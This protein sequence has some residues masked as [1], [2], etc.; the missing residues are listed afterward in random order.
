MKKNLFQTADQVA[1]RLRAELTPLPEEFDPC[2]SDEMEAEF[3]FYHKDPSVTAWHR[4]TSQYYSLWH[5][6][7]Y[8]GH[9]LDEMQPDTNYDRQFNAHTM[10]K[11]MAYMRDRYQKDLELVL[12]AHKLITEGTLSVLQGDKWSQ[13]GYKYTHQDWLQFLNKRSTNI[14]H[15]G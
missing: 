13:K 12:D 3:Q 4:L 11:E 9:L 5:Y 15:H 1:A 8:A 14:A 10:A 6:R 7:L 2:Y